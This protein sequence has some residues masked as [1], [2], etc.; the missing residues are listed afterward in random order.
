MPTKTL[1]VPAGVEIDG[2]KLREL[3][4]QRGINLTGFA[5]KCG[6][7]FGYLSQIE[8][9]YTSTVSP[10]IFIQLCDGFGFAESERSQ[11]LTKAARR[12]VRDA[13]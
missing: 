5:V 7:S 9:G 2:G 8:R 3:R 1:K 6:I 13:A 4:K 11:I 12:R 10:R